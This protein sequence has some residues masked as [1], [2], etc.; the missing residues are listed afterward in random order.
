MSDVLPE[1]PVERDAVSTRD[2]WMRALAIGLVI[3]AIGISL[4][5]SGF[6]AF[7]CSE[8][9]EAPW[10]FEADLCDGYA[11][12]YGGWAWLLAL[13]WPA[14]AFGLSQIVPTFRRHPVAVAA[15]IAIL[16]VAFWLVTGALVF[17]V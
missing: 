16:E 1:R 17:D 14:F 12:S 9:Y 15:P 6:A 13:L 10:S 7:A 3:A 4:L 5:V 11:G 8:G 2:A